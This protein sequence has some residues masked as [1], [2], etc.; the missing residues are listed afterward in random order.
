MLLKN[1]GLRLAL[2]VR[3]FSAAFKPFV[4][5]PEPASAGGTKPFSDFFNGL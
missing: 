1:S 2:V 5:H 3:R 4:S